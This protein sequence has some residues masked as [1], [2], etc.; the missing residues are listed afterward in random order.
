MEAARARTADRPG[1]H[2]AL[3]VLGGGFQTGLR[4]HAGL[5]VSALPQFGVGEVFQDAGKERGRRIGAGG[6]QR[7][8]ED[9]SCRREVAQ[10]ESYRARGQEPRGLLLRLQYVQYGAEQRVG[11]VEVAVQSAVHA[12]AVSTPE[13]LDRIVAISL[14]WSPVGGNGRRAQCVERCEVAGAVASRPGSQGGMDARLARTGH[15]GRPQGSGGE[16]QKVV[17]VGDGTV[18]QQAEAERHLL[19]C[20]R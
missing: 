5:V 17:G 7:E 2:I 1:R 20:G 6:G 14:A 11:A 8:A 12:V 4:V 16:K 10:H 13:G 3:R 9:L 19:V 18:T 15:V